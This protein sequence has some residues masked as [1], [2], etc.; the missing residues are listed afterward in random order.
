MQ[1]HRARR[2][3]GFRAPIRH[4]EKLQRRRGRSRSREDAE[5]VIQETFSRTR[6]ERHQAAIAALPPSFPRLVPVDLPDDEE[7]AFNARTNV[8]MPVQ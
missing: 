8:T 4:L 3:E 5:D 6:H 7:S 1:A 2:I